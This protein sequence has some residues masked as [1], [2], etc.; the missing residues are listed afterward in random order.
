MVSKLCSRV[1]AVEFVM[2]R[3][4]HPSKPIHKK[5]P[6]RPKNHKLE[7]AVLVKENK[8]V[9]MHNTASI[10]MNIFCHPNFL[11]QQLYAGKRYVS[12]SK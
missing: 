1:G 3:F 12:V 5:H 2:L 7:G 4:V 11:N 10:P 6:N 8:K 9:V